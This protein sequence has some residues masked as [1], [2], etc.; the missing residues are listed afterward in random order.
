MFSYLNLTCSFWKLIS[1]QNPPNP[2]RSL[3]CESQCSNVT[4]RWPASLSKD[5]I[6]NEYY[7]CMHSPVIGTDPGTGTGIRFHRPIWCIL[8]G[9]RR[10]DRTMLPTHNH[11][12]IRHTHE[13]Y[14]PCWWVCIVKPTGALHDDTTRPCNLRWPP[15]NGG[16]CSTLVKHVAYPVWWSFRHEQGGIGERTHRAVDPDGYLIDSLTAVGRSPEQEISRAT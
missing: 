8:S 12:Q 15:C 1:V 14:P 7:S 2:S 9:L 6:F 5:C 3:H 4:R 10:R 11:T 16:E 13:N